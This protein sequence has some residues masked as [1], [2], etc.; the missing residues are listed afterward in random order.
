MEEKIICAAIWYEELP[1]QNFLPI[2][3]KTGIVIC[4]HRH[5]HCIDVVKSLAN[6]RTVQISPDGVGKS[7]QGFLTNTNR[8]V[9]RQEAY[10]IAKKQNQLNDRLRT[11]GTL[12]SE[13]IY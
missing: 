13:D 11:E 7:T 10:E 12:Y 8:F 3:I 6:L 9:D 1:T 2:N 4:G 5:G